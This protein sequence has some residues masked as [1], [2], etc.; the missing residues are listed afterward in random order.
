M[1]PRQKGFASPGAF[2]NGLV[3][4]CD[5]LAAGKGVRVCDSVEDAVETIDDFM[6]K[7]ILGHPVDRLL[8][9]EKISGREV[10]SFALCKGKEFIFLG[11]ACDYK[12][13]TDGD[14]GPNTGGM[15]CYSPPDWL[16]ESD[17]K[18]IQEIILQ[19]LEGM[20]EEKMPFEGFLFLG[21]M[22]SED[23]PMVL[24]YNVRLGDPEAQVL[25]CMLP[26][27]FT[28]SVLKWQ[29][30]PFVGGALQQEMGYA[31][32]VV[33]ASDG[34]PLLSEEMQ[35][36]EVIS[37]DQKALHLEQENT[38]AKVFYAGVKAN[39]NSELVTA[40]GRVLGITCKHESREVCLKGLYR[41]VDSVNY[42][43][44]TFRRDI[45]V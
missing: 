16:S 35:L 29:Q 21:S 34:Y 8:I 4:K 12:R 22:I 38:Q 3:I 40:G 7:K 42:A 24:E 31:A 41:A 1:P 45:G 25:L 30:E 32:H 18:K 5:G 2:P 15:G 27:S 14:L 28:E 23:G 6:N 11:H 20:V 39:D 17:E 43:G 44:K 36:G 13:L 37:V 9:E 19:T 10:S 26:N 33:L